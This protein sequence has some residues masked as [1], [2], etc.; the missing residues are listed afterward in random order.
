MIAGNQ[1]WKNESEKYLKR[2]KLGT[3]PKVSRQLFL[4][5]NYVSIDVNKG[6]DIP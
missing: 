1:I 2:E 4:Y 3:Q 5:K 6:V